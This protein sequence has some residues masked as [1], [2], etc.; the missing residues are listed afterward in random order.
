MGQPERPTESPN[1]T[2]NFE[3]QLKP[4]TYQRSDGNHFRQM[5]EQLYRYMQVNP[6]QASQL[7]QLYPGIIQHVQP[8][9]RGGFSP[10]APRGQSYHHDPSRPGILQLV[11][12]SEHQSPGTVQD[13]LHPNGQGGRENWGGGAPNR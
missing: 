10:S 13:S 7:E 1:Y 4:G 5:N 11:P 12:R 8:G 3:G 6:D 9:A 2:V